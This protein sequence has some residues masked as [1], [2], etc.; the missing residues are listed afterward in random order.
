MQKIIQIFG[1][2]F[3]LLLMTCIPVVSSGQIAIDLKIPSSKVLLYEPVKASVVIRNSSGQMLSFD[4]DRVMTQLRFDIEMG[5]GTVIRR[6]NAVPLMSGVRIM[7][8]ET[9]SFEFNVSKFYDIRK[10][11]QYT[12]QAV[13]TCN[14]V[15][16]ASQCRHFE[17]VE[18]CELLR[19]RAGIPGDEGA[20]RTYIVEYLQRGRGE[21]LYLRIKDERE[22]AIYGVFNLGRIVRVRMPELKVDEA[23][24]VHVLFQTIGMSYIHTSFTP[25]G[26]YLSSTN[27]VGITSGVLLKELPNGKMTVVK[28]EAP[29]EKKLPSLPDMK[30]RTI[31]KEKNKRQRSLFN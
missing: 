16:Y 31:E 13:I 1:R 15:D 8:G 9:R 14:S 26:V 2:G 19:A 30:E 18:G 24:N 25:Y 21:D 6:L 4:S 11:G 22:N 23:G 5:N 17:V 28:K 20:V 12:I 29:V 3:A 27:L 10:L 7:T